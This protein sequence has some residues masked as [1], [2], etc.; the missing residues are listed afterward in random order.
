M[1]F[2]ERSNENFS[3]EPYNAFLLSTASLKGT[4]NFKKSRANEVYND[5][6]TSFSIRSN[7][8]T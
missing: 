2:S 8:K 7:E 5:K 6:P 3:R 1:K 4:G